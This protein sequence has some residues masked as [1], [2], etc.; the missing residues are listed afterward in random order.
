MT[1]IG[2]VWSEG[3][4]EGGVCRNESVQGGGGVVEAEEVQLSCDDDTGES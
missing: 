3:G 4:G 2:E 1:G